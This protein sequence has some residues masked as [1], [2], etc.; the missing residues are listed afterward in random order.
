V[1]L[2]LLNNREAQGID[3]LPIASWLLAEGGR[4]RADATDAPRLRTWLTAKQIGSLLGIG[5]G[6]EAPVRFDTV[7]PAERE[8]VVQRGSLPLSAREGLAGM[9]S[10]LS[11]RLCASR[12][13]PPL[14][15]RAMPRTGLRGR[16]GRPPRA[17]CDGAKWRAG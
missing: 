15:I 5:A 13:S 7:V 6:T 2:A 10:S 3:A 1:L 17:P 11:P 14:P 4:S 8:A 9:R 16:T 12:R